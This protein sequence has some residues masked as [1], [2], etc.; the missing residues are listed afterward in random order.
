MSAAEEVFAN[1]DIKYL[2]MQFNTNAIIVEQKIWHKGLFKKC[3]EVIGD[4]TYTGQM[5]ASYGPVEFDDMSTWEIISIKKMH[6]DT[7][8]GW[9]PSYGYGWREQYEFD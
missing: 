3:I 2:V 7:I 8:N 9:H 4:Q 1:G 6:A 5:L